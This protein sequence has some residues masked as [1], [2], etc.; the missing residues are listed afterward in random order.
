[1]AERF[2]L[3]NLGAGKNAMRRSILCAIRLK[4]RNVRFD[5]KLVAKMIV[6]TQSTLSQR[7]RSAMGFPT[8]PDHVELTSGLQA[9][10]VVAIAA[11]INAHDCLFTSVEEVRKITERHAEAFE[12]IQGLNDGICRDIFDKAEGR[13]GEYWG[14]IRENLSVLLDMLHVQRVY[15]ERWAQEVKPEEYLFGNGNPKDGCSVCKLQPGPCVFDD[16]V[17]RVS[18]HHDAGAVCY[19]LKLCKESLQSG[20]PL[21]DQDFESLK[22]QILSKKTLLGI[23]WYSHPLFH[24]ESAC[25][26]DKLLNKEELKIFRWRGI[27]NI[28]QDMNELL[29]WQNLRFTFVQDESIPDAERKAKNLIESIHSGPD[30]PHRAVFE[31]FRVDDQIQNTIEYALTQTRIRSITFPPCYGSDFWS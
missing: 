6:L 13:V 2:K 26:S 1:M 28:R 11:I 10:A 8:T 27:E 3:P 30:S 15:G 9:V 18:L 5:A 20:D 21:R 23:Y 17:H 25:R 19:V 16:E 12:A 22:S 7:Y 29:S 24:I 4:H 31:R 14:A